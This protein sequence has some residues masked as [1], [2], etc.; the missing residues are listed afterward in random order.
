MTSAAEAELAALYITAQKL[1]PMRKTII[2]MGWLQS[3]TPIQTDNTTAESVV[4]EKIFS[5]KEI[6]RP[7]ATL[8]TLS[9]ST[10]SILFLLGQR[11]QQLG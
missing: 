8:V 11:T 9:G 1:V 3:P 10:N 6:Y 4:N 5:K 7:E 2:K